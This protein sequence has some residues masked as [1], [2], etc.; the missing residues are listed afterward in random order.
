MPPRAED[1][2]F[3]HRLVSAV[4]NTK[5]DRFRVS[6]LESSS[7]ADCYLPRGLASFG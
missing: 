2:A 3:P 1:A 6:K 7:A 5:V 4:G